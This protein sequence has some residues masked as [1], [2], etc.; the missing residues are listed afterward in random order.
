[1]ADYN[2][3]INLGVAVWKPVPADKNEPFARTS[4]GSWTWPK[5]PVKE[6]DWGK[7]L[8][9]GAGNAAPLGGTDG[10]NLNPI[11][12]ANPSRR[13]NSGNTNPVIGQTNGAPLGGTNGVNRNPIGVAVPQ[14]ENRAPRHVRNIFP[15]PAP[16]FFDPSGTAAQAPWGIGLGLDGIRRKV[17]GANNWWDDNRYPV[18]LMT[19][20]YLPGSFEPYEARPPAPDSALAVWR[21][22]DPNYNSWNTPGPGITAIPAEMF[23]PTSR[24]GEITRSVFEQVPML[25]LGAT[26]PLGA[27][28]AVGRTVLTGASKL[29]LPKFVKPK[30]AVDFVTRHLDDIAKNPGKAYV[31]DM[32]DGA[33]MMAAAAAAGK[34][35]PNDPWAQ[36]LAAAAGGAGSFGLRRL[37]PGTVSAMMSRAAHSLRPIVAPSA[38]TLLNTGG[39]SNTARVT[40]AALTAGLGAMQPHLNQPLVLRSAG[41]IGANRRGTVEN[42]ASRQRL[43]TERAEERTAAASPVA[44]RG[45]FGGPENRSIDQILAQM[46]AEAAAANLVR[47]QQQ[48]AY[49]TNVAGAAGL[50]AARNGP[51]P[52]ASPWAGDPWF[53]SG[54]G[55][56]KNYA[57]FVG[58]R[59]RVHSAPSPA[60]V[61]A[62]AQARAQAQAQTFAQQ[63]AAEAMARVQQQ[64]VDLG[65]ESDAQMA[66]R[67]GY[68][69]RAEVQAKQLAED[70][71]ARAMADA[72][73]EYERQQAEEDAARQ[74]IQD[75][76]AEAEYREL[77][78]D[79]QTYLDYGWY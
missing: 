59:D 63:R 66:R 75:A 56:P 57:E 62:Q 6:P 2:D 39:P 70:A 22:E 21:G 54:P 32:G 24:A 30:P 52:T 38:N 74:E 50:L 76:I 9:V 20:G 33:V 72:Q 42:R 7:K 53:D 23:S 17:I 44:N 71:A 67:L 45:D 25:A 5:T 58:W 77:S 37:K 11:G 18:D 48:M 40:A 49:Q 46:Q 51:G 68:R 43:F 60:Q 27:A 78:D 28:T 10:A 26:M 36:W 13:G 1:M 35:F 4:R 12:A 34:A 3:S 14:F 15:G 19:G 16:D 29:L 8:D 64:R 47:A 73:E 65:Q 69:T 31:G 55:Y 41:Q 79:E 61:Q